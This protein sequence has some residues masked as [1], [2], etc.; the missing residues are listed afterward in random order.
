VAGT[1]ENQAVC[2]SGDNWNWPRLEPV[3]PEPPLRRPGQFIVAPHQSEVALPRG[4]GPRGRQHSGGRALV[5]LA[6]NVDYWWE[7]GAVAAGV[8]RL[9][10]RSA[11]PADHHP[12]CRPGRGI[13]AGPFLWTRVARHSL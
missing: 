9:L 6:V 13:S 1:D 10:H 5:M 12:P 8:F 11:G 2:W 3:P 4:V 7:G